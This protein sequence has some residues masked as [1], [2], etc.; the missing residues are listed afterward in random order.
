MKKILGVVLAIALVG[1]FINDVGR[2]ARTRYNLSIIAQQAAQAAARDRNATRDQ[3]AVK[4][5]D[6]AAR[7]GA[8]VYLYDQT[9]QGVHVWV[10]APVQGTWVWGPFVAWQNDEPL[11]TPFKVTY[12]ETASF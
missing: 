3:N 10:E 9:D 6:V 4:A 2:Y 11:S 7:D 5:A 12:D 8:T 1:A